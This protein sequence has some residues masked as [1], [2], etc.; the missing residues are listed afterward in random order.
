MI[1][2]SD[3]IIH[4]YCLDQTIH[5]PI[6]FMKGSCYRTI[7]PSQ[8]NIEDKLLLYMIFI[9]EKDTKNI[10]RMFLSEKYKVRT[11]WSFGWPGKSQFPSK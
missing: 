1:R 3:E 11:D 4:K 2:V 10:Y 9:R 5:C 7:C 8:V 6:Y